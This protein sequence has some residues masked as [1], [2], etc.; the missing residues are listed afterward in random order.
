M[1]N[2]LRPKLTCKLP[3]MRQ[4]RHK[5]LLRPPKKLDRGPLRP[6]PHL[7]KK[8]NNRSPR[9]PSPRKELPKQQLIWKKP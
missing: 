7:R 8:F 4:E 9:L 5:M 2:S 3:R 1:R 6:R